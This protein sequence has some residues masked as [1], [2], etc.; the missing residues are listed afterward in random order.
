MDEY[1]NSK[2]FDTIGF[3]E[4]MWVRTAGGKYFE[5]ICLS[6][7]VDD[8]FLSCKLPDVVSKFKKD[9]LRRFVGT[10]EGEVTEYLGCELVRKRK[11]Y[12]GHLVQAGYTERV[13]RAFDAWES[14]PVA[15][16]L[17]PNVRLSKLDCPAVVNPH[18][19]RKYRSIV[20]C[21]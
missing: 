14:H 9:L 10:D 20:G 13:L 12:T 21:I 19:H 18:V 11:T 6:A 3:E 15:T 7:H 2:G 8:C 16:P 1:F 4:S 5:D 17:D